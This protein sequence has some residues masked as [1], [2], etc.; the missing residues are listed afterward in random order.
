MEEAWKGSFAWGKNFKKA[1][2]KVIQVGYK[3]QTSDQAKQA[4]FN[5]AL[6]RPS[7]EVM[8]SKSTGTEER[9]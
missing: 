3:G 8:L 4:D 7:G 1:K 9:N 6:V 2:H 5:Q